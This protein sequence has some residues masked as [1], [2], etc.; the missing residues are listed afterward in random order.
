MNNFE[1]GELVL[2]RAPSTKAE[3]EEFG[4]WV[5]IM[6][7]YDGCHALILKDGGRDHTN[8]VKV[9]PDQPHPV[10][11]WWNVNYMDHIN[12]NVSNEEYANILFEDWQ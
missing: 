5:E 1:I 2:L 7:P 8:Y 3:E 12:N 11:L 6:R 10:N 9:N 4:P